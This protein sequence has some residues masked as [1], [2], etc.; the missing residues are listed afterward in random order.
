VAFDLSGKEEGGVLM[1][2]FFL[3]PKVNS[4]ILVES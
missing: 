3:F 2:F 4:E 1:F